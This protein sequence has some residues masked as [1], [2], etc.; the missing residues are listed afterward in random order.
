MVKPS[1]IAV[2]AFI[3][4]AVASAASATPI[5]FIASFTPT[6][7]TLLDDVDDSYSFDHD[8][9]LPLLATG[10]TRTLD[11]YINGVLTPGEDYD[12]TTDSLTAGTLTLNFTTCNESPCTS[13]NFDLDLGGTLSSQAF[14]T[15]V[16]VSN[17]AQFQLSGITSGGILS[18]KITRT[19]AAGDL[20]FVNSSLDVSGDRVISGS[21]PVTPVPEPGSLLLLGTGLV[22][23]GSRIRAWR[24][25]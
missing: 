3:L 13:G 7:Q 17:G 18:V 21:D 16:T 24:R 6:S 8:L 10:G 2:L 11:T 14:S 20:Y 25:T 9:T 19:N 1:R 23:A 15:I 22:A 4:S 12:S 5:Q